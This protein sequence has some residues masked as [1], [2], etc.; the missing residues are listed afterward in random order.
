[1]PTGEERATI[2]RLENTLLTY[3]NEMKLKLII[4]EYSLDDYSDYLA[5]LENLGLK[6]Y[7]SVYEAQH[8]RWLAVAEAI[9][10][11]SAYN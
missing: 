4:G 10:Q 5:E 6:E 3:I 2:E 7:I 8:A 11:D 9:G 1:M